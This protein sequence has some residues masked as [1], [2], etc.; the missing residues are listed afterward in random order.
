MLHTAYLRAAVVDL[1]ANLEAKLRNVSAIEACVNRFGDDANAMMVQRA[2]NHLD[3]VK[4]LH[5]TSSS[6]LCAVDA[7]L[8][9]VVVG[10]E[11]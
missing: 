11:G 5:N 6:L 7:A 1:R 10:T 4:K 2:A 9:G 8:T 3:A